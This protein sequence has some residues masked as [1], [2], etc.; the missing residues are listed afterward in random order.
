[1]RRFVLL[2]GLL[3]LAS[4]GPAP[5]WARPDTTPEQAARDHNECGALA[6]QEARLERFHYGPF[7]D[8][9]PFGYSRFGRPYHHPYYPFG[10]DNSF[11]REQQL[12]SF[13][14]RSRGYQLQ[15]P[16]PAYVAPP[17]LP[18]Q[19]QLQPQP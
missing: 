19:P 9:Y 6:W 16:Q 10:F 15:S 5:Y 17:P 14:M 11:F 12:L 1:M 7:F 13:C 18:P 3:T 2:L 4:C 8:P